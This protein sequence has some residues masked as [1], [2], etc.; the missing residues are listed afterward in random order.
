MYDDDRLH[1]YFDNVLHTV[2]IVCCA[3]QKEGVSIEDTY[4]QACESI[5]GIEKRMKEFRRA[6]KKQKLILM[7]TISN[8]I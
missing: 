2:K 1:N 6:M 3:R 8:Q 7:K 5:E 4:K